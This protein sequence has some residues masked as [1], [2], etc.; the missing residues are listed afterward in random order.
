MIRLSSLDWLNAPQV[1]DSQAFMAQDVAC[2]LVLVVTMKIWASMFLETKNVFKIYENLPRIFHGLLQL[3][4]L[5]TASILRVVNGKDSAH[6]SRTT[7]LIILH[8]W[9]NF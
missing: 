2:L 9:I 4:L 5:N 8:N 1:D 3:E 7:P 6:F